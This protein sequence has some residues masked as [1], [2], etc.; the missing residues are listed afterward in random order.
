MKNEDPTVPDTKQQMIV[1]VP[2]VI[3]VVG[4]LAVMRAMGHNGALMGAVYGAGGGLVGGI[5]GQLLLK[6]LGTSSK[7]E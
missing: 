3:G 4:S 5:V 6:V 2:V 1:L 7:D